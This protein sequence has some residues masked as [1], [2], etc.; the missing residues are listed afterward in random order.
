[1][2]DAYDPIRD[3]HDTVRLILEN[4]VTSEQCRDIFKCDPK[5]Q[6]RQ[7]YQKKKRKE[8]STKLE[9]DAAAGLLPLE[10]SP[11]DLLLRLDDA[12][13]DADGDLFEQA[14]DDFN[15]GMRQLK[16]SGQMQEN[17]RKMDGLKEAVWT[18]ISSQAYD[19][20]VSPRV[21]ELRDY[22]PFSD[23]VSVTAHLFWHLP[24][25]LNSADTNSPRA[26]ME[27]CSR[28]SSTTSST[29]PTFGLA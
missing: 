9:A 6:P 5:L 3:L 18:R 21:G 11:S 10:A 22:K 19:R 4:F 1:M 2:K 8:A 29:R 28:P 16:E 24:W 25:C 27:S 13:H 20:M 12:I 15:R 23:E 17:I 14:L 26:D 7:R